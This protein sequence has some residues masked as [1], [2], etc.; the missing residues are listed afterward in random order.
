MPKKSVC[1][2]VDRY[3]LVMEREEKNYQVFKQ[4]GCNINI[5]WDGSRSERLTWESHCVRC[6]DSF[7]TTTNSFYEILSVTAKCP[8]CIK[9]EPF[10]KNFRPKK[11]IRMP[12]EHK[13]P[14]WS[15]CSG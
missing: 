5:Q 4:I 10:Y 8:K 11:L 7:I 2:K 6:G 12:E 1:D 15:V 3:D 9:E 13:N 14:F